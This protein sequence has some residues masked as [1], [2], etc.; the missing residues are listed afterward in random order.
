MEEIITR[1]D[2]LDLTLDL[3]DFID[4]EKGALKQA[5]AACILS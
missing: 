1:I 4:K 3:N 5:L 2:T